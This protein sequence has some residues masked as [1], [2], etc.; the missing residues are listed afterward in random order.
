VPRMAKRRKTTMKNDIAWVRDGMEWERD[1]ISL[2]IEGNLLILLR[3]R[4]TLIVLKT[5]MFTEPC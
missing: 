4:K 1:R 5:R 3:G 2:F